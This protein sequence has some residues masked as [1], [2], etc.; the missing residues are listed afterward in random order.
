MTVLTRVEGNQSVKTN[1][2]EK[3]KRK[4]KVKRGLTLMGKERVRAN[5]HSGTKGNGNSV[6]NL[7]STGS[8]LFPQSSC[9]YERGDNIKTTV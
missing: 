8:S 2:K 1:R 6:R 7:G 9:L 4:K 3:G 5:D